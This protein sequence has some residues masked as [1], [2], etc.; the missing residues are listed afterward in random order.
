MFRVLWLPMSTAFVFRKNLQYQFYSSHQTHIVQWVST[1]A[2]NRTYFKLWARSHN[3][4]ATTPRILDHSHFSTQISAAAAESHQSRS[5][6]SRTQ[7]FEH[8]HVCLLS[9]FY[10][11]TATNWP[12]K[13]EIRYTRPS[14]A[15]YISKLKRCDLLCQAQ[16]YVRQILLH[17]LTYLEHNINPSKGMHILHKIYAGH[18]GSGEQLG[19]VHLHSLGGYC[20]S[21]FQRSLTLK[22][23][24]EPNWPTVQGLW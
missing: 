4:W 15:M 14:Y 17:P 18:F 21:R 6:R 12:G 7:K 20:W 16:K 2:T 22:S 9:P 11:E 8:L 10:W 19:A 24:D 1:T 3:M 13:H 5:H 23:W